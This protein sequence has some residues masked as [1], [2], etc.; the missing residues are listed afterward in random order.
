MW[1]VTSC[2][3]ADE[4]VMA[5]CTRGTTWSTVETFCLIDCWADDEIEAGLSGIHRNR[6]VYTNISYKMREHGYLR[7]WDTC[8]NKI[9]SLRVQYP[10]AK[11][12][13]NTSGQERAKFIFSEHIDKFM[14]TRPIVQLELVVNAGAEYVNIDEE[15][16][17]STTGK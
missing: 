14:G 1:L 12:H 9:K 15:N 7:S 11:Q 4:Q 6:H 2:G 10:R 16:V 3:S 8:R 13:N 5:D 17:S